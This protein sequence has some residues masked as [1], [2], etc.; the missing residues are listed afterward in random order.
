MQTPGR[1]ISVSV[2]VGPARWQ[3]FQPTVAVKHHRERLVVRP[4]RGPAKALEALRA[5]TH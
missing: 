2:R 3:R 4:G 1:R 5:Q